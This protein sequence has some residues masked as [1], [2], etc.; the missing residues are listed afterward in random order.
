MKRTSPRYMPDQD[1]GKLF[2]TL[3]QLGDKQLKPSEFWDDIREGNLV[4]IDSLL[5]PRLCVPKKYRAA[6]LH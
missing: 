4:W 2:Q 3:D 5:N 6:I 1:N